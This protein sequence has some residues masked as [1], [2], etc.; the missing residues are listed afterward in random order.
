MARLSYMQRRKSGIYEFRMRLPSALAGQPAPAHLRA[1]FPELVNPKTG[2]FK[3]E[4]VRSLGTSDQ[5]TAARLDLK[6]A[7]DTKGQFDAAMKALT[8]GVEPPT[9]EPAAPLGNWNP[10]QLVS[11]LDIIERET[12]AELLA[13]DEEERDFGD[14]RR[15]LQTR[16]ERAQWP[17]LVPIAEPWA[18]GMAIEHAVAYRNY[19]GEIAGEY[20]E[21]RARHDPAI[22][23]AETHEAMR[24]HRIP[25]DPKSE[26][27]HR[28]GIAVLTAHVRAF[29]AMLQRQSGEIVETPAPP[30]PSSQAKA[31]PAQQSEHSVAG[32]KLSEAFALWQEGGSAAGSRK[33]GRS[34]ILEARPAVRWFIEL[35]GDM[36]LGEI[37]KAHAREY[38]RAI[39]RV[40]NRL[41]RDHRSLTL[42][43]L[44]E[45]I[46]EGKL[47]GGYEPRGATTVNKSLTIVIRRGRLTL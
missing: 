34:G 7:H 13:R 21:A 6:Y 10:Q 12:L 22:V 16:E 41:P 31:Q 29:N 4:I 45:R 25:L 1:A 9:P 46:G 23:Q 15:R 47:A 38:Q 24:R 39:A 8:R 2:R 14:D 36:H 11:V 27:F 26:T 37:T 3:L 43:K 17:D 28:V 42:P 33:P 19:L 44:L 18:R 35:H 32:P 20:R 30:P 5:K 40:P